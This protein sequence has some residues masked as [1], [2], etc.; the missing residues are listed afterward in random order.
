MAKDWDP[1]EGPS[2]TVTGKEESVNRG[3]YDFTEDVLNARAGDQEAFNNLYW[4]ALPILEREAK[5]FFP[6]Q[7][8]REDALQETFIRIYEKL[9]T[10]HDP[11]TFMG[12]AITVCK[13]TCLNRLKSMEVHTGKDDFRP[14]NSEEDDDSF[15]A[16]MD[17]LTVSEYRRDVDPTA[18]VDKEHVESVVRAILED[19]PENQQMCLALWMDG[20]ST[21][22]IAE[23][24]GMPPGTVKSNINYAK[25]KVRSRLE[26]MLEEGT[27]DYHAISADPVSAFLYLLEQY[28]SRAPASAI[29]G[30]ALL[31]TIQ[32]G[33]ESVSV[34]GG[35]A[36]SAATAL[37][38]TG[39]RGGVHRLSQR[40]ATAAVSLVATVALAVGVALGLQTLSPKMPAEVRDRVTTTEVLVEQE[41]RVRDSGIEPEAQR[42]DAEREDTNTN[43]EEAA[44]PSVTAVPT[45]GVTQGRGNGSG[46]ASGRTRNTTVRS[47]GRLVASTLDDQTFGDTTGAAFAQGF[48][49]LTAPLGVLKKVTIYVNNP[50]LQSDDLNLKIMFLNG[51]DN[52]VTVTAVENFE[53]RNIDGD[54]IAKTS[55][56]LETPAT[57]AAN[58]YK[59]YSLTIPSGQFDRKV[60]EKML[61][62]SYIGKTDYSADIIYQ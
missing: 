58:S 33:L 42:E 13:T 32:T 26:K 30:D 14:L 53:F 22:E 23:E 19:L 59:F 47:N 29:G 61:E 17:T 44:V 24:L 37:A 15:Y 56:D 9:G 52:T 34:G 60:L 12:W 55:F 40:P 6:K 31:K 43:T 4:K 41:E 2:I 11:K 10:L 49:G 54:V 45:P 38:Q 35:A 62:G 28:Y 1:A 46:N 36:A 50:S 20:F 57:I 8:D 21:K 48:T 51:L 27:F 3:R 25:K 39:F 7:Q 18:H 16:G 5:R